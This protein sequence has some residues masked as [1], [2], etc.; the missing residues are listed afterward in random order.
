MTSWN[1]GLGLSVV[2]M[3][4]L[5]GQVQILICKLLGLLSASAGYS[6]EILTKSPI[7]THN[8][9][10][11]DVF[12]QSKGFGA[13]DVLPDTRCYIVCYGNAHQGSENANEAGFKR[14][15]SDDDCYVSPTPGLPLGGCG[16]CTLTQRYLARPIPHGRRHTNIRMDPL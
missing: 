11:I 1:T 7:S 14:C 6:Y 9:S 5:I 12:C 15:C 4:M 3:V 2:N 13:Y 16:P 10:D 8:K